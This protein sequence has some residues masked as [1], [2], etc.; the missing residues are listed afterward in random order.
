MIVLL[1]KKSMNGIG[2]IKVLKDITQ[3][4]FSEMENK[5]NQN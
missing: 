2:K 5:I 4:K 1:G 3:E